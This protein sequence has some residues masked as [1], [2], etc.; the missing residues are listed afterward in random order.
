VRGGSWNN[1]RNNAR[2]AYRNRNEPDNFNNNLGFRLVVCHAFDPGQEC[3]SLTSGGRGQKWR[4]CPRLA[5][6]Q[7]C[8]PGRIYNRPGPWVNT[9]GRGY[10]FSLIQRR[11]II[12]STAW[13]RHCLK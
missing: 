7:I 8:M 10:H 6:G 4:V 1:N 12:S 3:C 11:D 13:G 5:A 9:L 2:C